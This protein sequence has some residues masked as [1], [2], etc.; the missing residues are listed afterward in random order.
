MK[1]GVE[2]SKK[3]EIMAQAQMLQMDALRQVELVSTEVA[4]T[5]QKCHRGAARAGF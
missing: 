1:E 5:G 3:A 2:E 4:K